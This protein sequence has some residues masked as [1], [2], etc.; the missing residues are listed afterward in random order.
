MQAQIRREFSNLLFFNISHSNLKKIVRWDGMKS[1]IW[2]LMR[3][4]LGRKFPGISSLIPIYCL[5]RPWYWPLFSVE[6]IKGRQGV[7]V[8]IGAGKGGGSWLMRKKFLVF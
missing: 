1:A 3:N 7:V 5:Q 8:V 4:A 2:S 6:Q